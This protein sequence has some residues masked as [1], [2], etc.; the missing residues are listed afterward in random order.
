[1]FMHYIKLFLG[2][3]LFQ[4]KDKILRLRDSEWEAILEV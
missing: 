3:Y 4:W 1:M 2:K